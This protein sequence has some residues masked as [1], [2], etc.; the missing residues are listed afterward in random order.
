MTNESKEPLAVVEGYVKLWEVEE[1][2]EHPESLW[3]ITVD[4][5]PQICEDDE[6]GVPVAVIIMERKK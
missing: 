6:E 1:A 3:C 4:P 2:I 5:L